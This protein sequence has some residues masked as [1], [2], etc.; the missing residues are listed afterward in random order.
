LLL[1]L[2]LC[3]VTVK[4]P[5]TIIQNPVAYKIYKVDARLIVLECIAV[6]S[7]TPR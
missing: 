3:S 2:F 4:L 1:L 6:G 5:P 7:P